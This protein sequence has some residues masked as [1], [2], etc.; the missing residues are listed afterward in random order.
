MTPRIK[1]LEI[2]PDASAAQ[3]AR[4]FLSPVPTAAPFGFSQNSLCS[5]RCRAEAPMS[6]VFAR[7]P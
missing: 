2:L 4:E 5:W 3:A 7:E 1:A 6:P